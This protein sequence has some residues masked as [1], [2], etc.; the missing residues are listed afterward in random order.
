MKQVQGKLNNQCQYVAFLRGI[1]VG[2]HGLIRMTD[3]K[4]AF[5]KMGFKN[6]RTVLASG[7]VVFESEQ[8]DKIALGKEIESSLKRVFE[9]EISV[10]L[11]SRNEL[12]KLQSSEPFEGITMNSDIRL[13]VTFLSRKTGPRTISIPYSSQ[14]KEFRIIHATPSEVLSVLDLSKG[15]GTTDLMNILEKEFGSDVTTRNWNTVLKLLN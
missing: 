13:Y 7:N 3:L 4:I 14:K 8:E 11:R 1:N 9:K 5:E 6:V 10:I 12:K 15:K 2:G